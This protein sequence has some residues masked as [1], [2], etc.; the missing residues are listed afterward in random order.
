MKMHGCGQMKT[1]SI[2]RIIH[3]MVE[4]IHPLTHGDINVHEKRGSSCFFILGLN[5]SQRS[6]NFIKKPV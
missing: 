5:V 6:D 4:T 1:I 2:P 3:A